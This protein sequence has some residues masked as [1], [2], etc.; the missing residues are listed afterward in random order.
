LGAETSR[1]EEVPRVPQSGGLSTD[2][3]IFGITASAEEAGK[4]TWEGIELMLRCWQGEP[5][6]FEGDFFRLS[7]P[8]S[9]EDIGEWFKA[10]PSMPDDAVTIDYLLD[11]TCIVGSPDEVVEKV[12]RLRERVGPFGYL[13]Q[14]VHDWWPDQS[15]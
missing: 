3:A 10:D 1:T 11:N 9:R 8:P 12:G 2:K 5:F 13:M 7:A 4:L 15:T 6:E 14:V